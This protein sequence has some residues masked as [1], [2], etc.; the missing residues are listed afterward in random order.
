[1][2]VRAIVQ[3][4]SISG[5]K[6]VCFTTDMVTPLE[7]FLVPWPEYT[8]LSGTVLLLDMNSDKLSEALLDIELHSTDTGIDSIEI[9]ENER[10]SLRIML[11]GVIANG[12]SPES[13]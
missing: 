3:T 12:N 9:T 2:K 5:Q 6:N 11:E 1:M 4:N 7:N 13:C 10:N 8:V